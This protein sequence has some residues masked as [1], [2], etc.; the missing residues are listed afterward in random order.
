MADD[1]LSFEFESHLDSA[2]KLQITAAGDG[3]DNV[4]EVQVA[5]P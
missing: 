5:F 1:G 2:P 3:Q 4:G